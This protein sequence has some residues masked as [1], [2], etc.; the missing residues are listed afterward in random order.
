MARHRKYGF[1][2]NLEQNLTRAMSRHLP[3]GDGTTEEPNRLPTLK[4]IRPLPRA[5]E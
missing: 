2:V 4:L 3:A 5:S 1:G